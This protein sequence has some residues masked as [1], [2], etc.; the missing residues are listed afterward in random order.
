MADAPAWIQHFARDA[1]N[2]KK[3]QR[4]NDKSIWNNSDR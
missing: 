3:S 2:K 4:W 1:K